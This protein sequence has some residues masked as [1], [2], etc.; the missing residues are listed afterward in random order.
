MNQTESISPIA[1]S[2]LM[3][4][5]EPRHGYDIMKQVAV[6]SD[7]KIK[8]GPGTLYGALKRFLD[9]GLVMELDQPADPRRRYYQLTGT[10]Q[11]RLQAELTR[12]DAA[13]SLARQRQILNLGY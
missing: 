5:A 11:Q 10:G 3:T 4:L 13:V 12:Y 1:I 7:G 9:S 2:I 6:D 8:L